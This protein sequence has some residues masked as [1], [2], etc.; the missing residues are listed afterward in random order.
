VPRQ[1]SELKRPLAQVRVRIGGQE[2]T[3]L[4][5]GSAPFFVSGCM[6]INVPV[7]ENIAP[8]NAVPVELIIGGVSSGTAVTMAVR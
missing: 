6:Q 4:Y 3:P 5:A 1:E 8:G 7:P 2:V